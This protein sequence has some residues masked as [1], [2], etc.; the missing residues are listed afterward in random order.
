MEFVNNFLD[1]IDT[2]KAVSKHSSV[3]SQYVQVTIWTA[4]VF[5]TVYILAK[6]L[7]YVATSRKAFRGYQLALGLRG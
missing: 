7:I 5:F 3:F 4:L 1:A 6:C 2:F